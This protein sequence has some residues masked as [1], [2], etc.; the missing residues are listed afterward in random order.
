MHDAKLKQLNELS[1][2]IDSFRQ[3]LQKTIEVMADPKLPV[4]N[5]TYSI[6]NFL[7]L[8]QRSAIVLL[9]RDDIEQELLR[10]LHEYE[11]A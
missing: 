3:K 9:I 6:G 5:L 10:M 8:S 11:A 7:S 2:R 4:D 1:E